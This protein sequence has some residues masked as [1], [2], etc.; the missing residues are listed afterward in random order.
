LVYHPVTLP[1]SA[2]FG[3]RYVHSLMRKWAASGTLAAKRMNKHAAGGMVNW[4]GW[5]I[6]GQIGL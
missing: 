6:D 3:L 2:A 4:G 5:V 1:I